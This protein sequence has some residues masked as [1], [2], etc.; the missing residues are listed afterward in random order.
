[1]N[2]YTLEE[3]ENWLMESNFASAGW[4]DP[5]YLTH[6]NIKKANEVITDEDQT[7]LDL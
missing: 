1:M 5:I 7:K 4:L 3:I 2:K 6:E